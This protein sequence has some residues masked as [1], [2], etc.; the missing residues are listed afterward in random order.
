M[1]KSKTSL[2]T[3]A[4]TYI[5]L[6]AVFYPL[7]AHFLMPQEGTGGVGSAS[8]QAFQGL[9]LVALLF[10]GQ[11][12]RE[13]LRNLFDVWI[14]GAAYFICV[15]LC[16]TVAFE[17]TNRMIEIAYC[18]RFVLWFLFA[19]IISR[20]AFEPRELAALAVSFWLGCILQ[21]VFALEAIITRS[22][23]SI[24]HEVFATTGGSNVSGKMA[25]AF[26]TLGGLMSIYWF[27]R[28]ARRRLV[29]LSGMA[30][31]GLVVLFS[32]NRS[33]QLSL[34]LVCCWALV[35]LFRTGRIKTATFFIFAAIG[36]CAL[37]VGFFDETF[38]VRWL[39][40]HE[41]GGSGRD[42][43]IKAALNNVMNPRSLAS[44]FFGQGY[45]HTKNLMYEACGSRIGTHSDL[46]DFLTVYGF[47]GLGFYFWSVFRILD[48]KRG[49][50]R[51]SL[52]YLCIRVATIF[53]VFMGLFTGLF[54]S[55]YVFIMLFTFVYY[56]RTARVSYVFA[57]PQS[58]RPLGYQRP[59]MSER[60]PEEF[61]R[62][63]YSVED[64]VEYE[65]E[66][67]ESDYVENYEENEYEEKGSP[68]AQTI[69]LTSLV[70]DDERPPQDDE[71]NAVETDVDE[72][73]TFSNVELFHEIWNNRDEVVDVLESMGKE[74]GEERED[75]S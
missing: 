14:V 63:L 69:D 15:T 57:S 40:I 67:D 64:S 30:L 4:I 11:F 46:F 44:L 53:V 24:Y 36:L 43:L 60:D 6:Y 52:E 27:V 31:S 70:N 62:Y 72:S 61:G 29:Y 58:R 74:N 38:M 18:G 42:K 21:G 1:I 12:G 3:L 73:T 13:S 22:G 37:M 54:Q 7:A 68:E 25:V 45:E 20:G 75:V 34:A 23:V 16:F 47:V 17:S 51:D 9:V 10:V 65:E 59:Y 49:V 48:L 2:K 41:D 5:C 28:D 26:I 39:N 56:W 8:V 71:S 66:D 32:Y 19:T 33:A 50:A 35:W 55:S